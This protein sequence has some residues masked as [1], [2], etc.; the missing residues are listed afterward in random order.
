MLTRDQ[1]EAFRKAPW[2]STSEVDDFTSQVPEPS[3]GDVERLL[4]ILTDKASAADAPRQRQRA[5]AFLAIAQ[6][7]RERELFATY[8]AAMKTAD[9]TARS[10]LAT[11]LPQVNDPSR[12][13]D[14]CD[15]LNSSDE[16]LRGAAA[17][18]LRAVGGRAVVERLQE[19]AGAQT[20]EGRRQAVDLLVA[21]AG[22]RPSSGATA[23]ATWETAT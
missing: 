15:L 13:G 14:L 12:H 1:L 22:H 23:C 20:F 8:V 21:L 11:L 5:T 2:T 4:G 18:V 16:D 17:R 3:R 6:K 9:R 10:A 19:M 7:V